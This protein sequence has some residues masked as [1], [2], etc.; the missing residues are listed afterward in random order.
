MSEDSLRRRRGVAIFGGL[1]VITAIAALT[2]TGPGDDEFASQTTT[3]L[4]PAESGR[5]VG[6]KVGAPPEWERREAGE[7]IRFRSPDGEVQVLVDYSPQAGEAGAALQA[8]LAAL[9]QRF[10]VASVGEPVEREI[11]GIEGQEVLVS[12]RDRGGPVN[13]LIISA[14]GKDHTYVIAVVSRPNAPEQALAEGQQIVNS[15]RLQ[16]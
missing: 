5:D 14:N 10:E 15:L 4:Q 9:Q 11:G 1:L 13:F 8:E 7:V 12:A 3:A 2:V 16:G 6:I